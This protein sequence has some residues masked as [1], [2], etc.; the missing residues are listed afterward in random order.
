MNKPEYEV[1]VHI[2]LTEMV[3]LYDEEI[4]QL[5]SEYRLS[6]DH[7]ENEVYC[8]MMDSLRRLKASCEAKLKLLKVIP[9]DIL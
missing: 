3:A 8:K 7:I 1:A 6:S 5:N 4:E 2:V 9:K